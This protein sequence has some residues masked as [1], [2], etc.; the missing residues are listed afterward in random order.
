MRVEFQE[1]GSMQFRGTARIVD[2][3]LAR[4]QVIDTLGMVT[5]FLSFTEVHQVVLAG[6]PGARL[7]LQLIL[8]RGEALE[9]GLVEDAEFGVRLGARIADLLGCTFG[10]VV[11]L[12][13]LRVRFDETEETQA[14]VRTVQIQATDVL[15]EVSDCTSVHTLPDGAPTLEVPAMRRAGLLSLFDDAAKDLLARSA[16]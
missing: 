2:F 11:R 9:L 13:S 6:P 8:R 15:E 10:G 3:D 7:A 5:K 4:R 14:F 16:D 12:P 1:D